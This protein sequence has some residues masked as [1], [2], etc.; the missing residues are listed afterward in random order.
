[1]IDVQYIRITPDT[2]LVTHILRH[3]SS[4]TLQVEAKD[5]SAKDVQ[6]EKTMLNITRTEEMRH[7]E[8]VTPSVVE[9][10]F[11]IGRIMYVVLEHAF[12]QREGDEQRNWLELPSLVAPVKVSRQKRRDSP[13]VARTFIVLG[14]AD[15]C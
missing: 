7:V 6:L 3:F 9:P 4:V 13:L 10:S 2:S 15:K 1:M 5:G 14:A 11:G 8:E 12:R